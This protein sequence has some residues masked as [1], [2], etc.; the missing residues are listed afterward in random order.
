MAAYSI[1]EIATLLQQPLAHIHCPTT[2]ITTLSFDTRSIINPTKTLFFALNGNEN[3]HNYIDNAYQN[4]VR[5]FVV[6]E[7]RTHWEHW[8]DANFFKVDNVLETLQKL[9]AKHREQFNI[10]VIGITGSNGKTIVK[11]WLHQ[12]L[13][14]EYNIVRSP[15]SYNSQIGVPLSVWQIKSEHQLGIFEAGISQIDEM[16]T[17]EQIIQPSIGILTN[18]KVAHDEGFE[19][20][21]QKIIEKIKLFTRT[22]TLIYSPDYIPHSNIPKNKRQF[23]WSFKNKQCDLFIQEVNTTQP[24]YTIIQAIYHNQ[25]INIEI[26]FNDDASIENAIICWSTLLF[27]GYEQKIIAERI[28]LLS[29][30][31]MRLEL[32]NG[33]NNCSIIDDS[34][35][36]DLVSL[37]IAL[38]FLLQQN[39]HPKRTVILSDIKQAGEEPQH[40]YNEVAYL[41]KNKK[42]N[43]LIGVGPQLKAQKNQFNWGI[44]TH[45][46]N[47][48]NELINNIHNLQLHDKSILIKGAREFEFEQIS[49]KLTQKIHQTILSINL[50]AIAHNLRHYRKQL[51]PNI[52]TMAMVKAFSYGS[53]SYEI[54]NLLQYHKVDYL[55]VAYADEGIALRQAGIQLPI[56]VMNPDENSFESLLKYHLEPQLYTFSILNSFTQ[57]T[58][59]KN[60]KNYPIHLKLDTGM[61]R[62]GFETQDIQELIQHANIHS[63][64]KIQSVLSHLVGSDANNH[65]DFTAKQ[66]D[67]FKTFTQQLQQ[68]LGYTFIKHICNTSG[69]SRWPQAHFDMVRL[70]IGLYGIDTSINNNAPLQNVASLSTTIAQIKTIAPNQSVGY[71]RS[72]T[73]PKGGKIATVKIG[74]AD[75]YLRQ[76]GNGVGHMLVN[77][78]KAPTV[79]NICM[80]MCMIDITHIPEAKEGDTVVVF[81]DILKVETIASWLHT[82][83]YE[84]L[85]NI[86]QRVKRIYHYDM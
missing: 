14:P 85:T 24:S 82:I 18:L 55:A 76:L 84:I 52:K 31:E 16:D 54:A 47:T 43:Q 73:M 46:F 71:S 39:Q 29:P 34:Y 79:G 69:I 25:S 63:S 21:Q 72:G 27:L 8:H 22:H 50:N 38:N 35:S 57:Y 48:T 32:K 5:N 60:V 53:G 65:D 66:I 30:I 78:K 58:Q 15:K 4:D 20:Q 6:N 44:E 75:G 26:P 3:G 70:G 9:S 28:K 68:A 67:L 17:L 41:L 86:S 51:A 23:T 62:L 64:I 13:T 36:C 11:E 59:A 19:N 1:Q 83:P 37:S 12:L 74:Y 80:D 81:N 56:M 2:H 33:I 42:I 45:F 7:W 10:P 40:L 61:K 77:N 49:K